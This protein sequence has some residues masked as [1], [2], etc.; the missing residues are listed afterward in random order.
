MKENQQRS[1]STQNK[2]LRRVQEQ[3]WEPE[4]LISGIVLFA[5][6]Q[7]A[8][9]LKAFFDYLDSYSYA[10]FSSSNADE[11]L[12]AV[13]LTANYW[14]I[15]GFT[16]HL[17]FRSVWVAF[18]G[19]S[20][21][22][23]DGVKLEQ[24]KFQKP[25]RK[26][27]EKNSDYVKNILFL[28]KV[29]SSV[30]AISFLLFMLTIGVFFFLLII[31]IILGT[32]YSI[33]PEVIL[34]YDHL[35]DPVLS[36]ILIIYFFDFI[37]LGL[38]KRIPYFSKMYY[39]Y[40]RLMGFLTLAPLYRNIYYG[41][42]S[43]HKRWK[44]ALG[45]ITFIMI[46]TVMIFNLRE[47]NNLLNALE[48]S[49]N[50]ADETNIY[51]GHYNNLMGDDPSQEIQIPSDVVSGQSLSCFIVANS[52]IE[53]KYLLK[54]CDF[55]SLA[56]LDAIDL[57]S[58]RLH[59]LSSF[60]KLR[61]DQKMIAA[62]FFYHK[63]QATNQEGVMAYLDLSTFGRGVHYL[64]LIHQVRDS[65]QQTAAVVQFYKESG[66]I[67]PAAEVDSNDLLPSS[68]ASLPSD[69]ASRPDQD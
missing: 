31:A 58:L 64:K 8:P 41:F 25:Y 34:E 43:N 3:S 44:V 9:G 23:K 47:E 29:C 15:A 12:K 32:T 68:P 6:F 19:L 52:A 63:K 42:V 55:D 24:L 22:Y 57:D 39:P 59:C 69:S 49:I 21:V 27:L 50:G 13:L 1:N 17:I 62:K 30:F 67:E 14:L 35:I 16:T 5:L 38:F 53:Q 46:S 26:I 66:A 61:I 2:W 33:F 45:M 7:I 4:I 37:T 36:V 65:I 60:Y 10:A 40:Y 20:Y 56:K 11:S 28:E 54:N 48:L 18:V 51:H